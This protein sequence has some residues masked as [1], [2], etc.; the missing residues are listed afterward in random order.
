M[1]VMDDVVRI[2]IRY[3]RQLYED[4]TDPIVF[5]PVAVSTSG[6]T[7]ELKMTL[8]RV[9]DDFVRLLFLH[10]HREGSILAGESPEESE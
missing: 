10:A 2:K 1:T 9:Y 3:Y 5:L 6:H 8:G 4:R 7:S